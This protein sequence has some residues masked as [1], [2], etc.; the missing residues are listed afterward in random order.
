MQYILVVAQEVALPPQEFVAAWNADPTCH[1]L[2]HASIDCSTKAVYE[3]NRRIPL[4]LLD[5]ADADPPT[6]LLLASIQ[7][8][9]QKRQVNKPTELIQVEKPDGNRVLLIKGVE[10]Q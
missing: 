3:P 7:Q 1:R 4:P 8:T 5:I 10:P 6:A 9:M 2:A